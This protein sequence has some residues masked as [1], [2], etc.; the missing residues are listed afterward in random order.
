[1]KLKMTAKAML[2]AGLIGV[3]SAQASTLMQYELGDITL[4]S[5]AM[6]NGTVYFVSYGIDGALNSSL[7][8]LAT[9]Q[10][11][12]LIGGDDKWLFANSVVGGNVQGN[13]VEQYNTGIAAGQSIVAFF[14]NG[15]SSSDVNY[16]TGLLLN[17][18]NLGASG[19]AGELRNWGSYRTNSIE[20]LGDQVGDAIS[21]VLPTN[22]G[23][24]A[25]IVAYSG[26][27]DY[28]GNDITANLQ[29]VNSVYL[30]PEPSTGALM[31]I[32]AAGLVALRRLRKV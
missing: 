28:T 8:S 30:V 16:S 21:W 19:A 7:S 20:T 10:S 3:S 9:A 27:G 1:M 11:T 24:T 23:A 31:M 32:G 25:T 29:A 13:W 22:V 6:L 15:L 14:V 26:T 12:S 2:V 4:G 5:G 17:S 18:K